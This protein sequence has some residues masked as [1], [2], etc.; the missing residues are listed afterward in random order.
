MPRVR[1]WRRSPRS[2]SRPDASWRAVDLRTACLAMTLSGAFWS[3]R[4]AVRPSSSHGAPVFASDCRTQFVKNRYEFASDSNFVAC[5]CIKVTVSINSRCIQ[6][7]LG[8]VAAHERAPR[9]LGSSR[10]AAEPKGG[11]L[12]HRRRML[13]DSSF[14][15]PRP[16]GVER[17]N[18]T[19]PP[20]PRPA[21]PYGFQELENQ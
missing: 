11:R 19:F 5:R 17:W 1:I 4:L 21:A 7:T 18:G 8:S 12:S 15:V 20:V 16:K 3:Y 13:S 14:H 2:A 9:D 10:I 6:V